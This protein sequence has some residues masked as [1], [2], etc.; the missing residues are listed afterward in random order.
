MD[1]KRALVTGGASGMGQAI[2]RILAAEGARVA[3]ADRDRDGAEAT[4]S[5]VNGLALDVDVGDAA[6]LEE[7]MQTAARELGGLSTLVNNAGIS[8]LGP[9][10]DYRSEDWE[11]TLEVN[12]TGVWNCMRAALPILREEGSGAAIVNNASLGAIRPPRG[13]V[14]YSAAKAGVVA[15]SCGAAQEFAPDIRVN[16][17]SPGLIRTPMSEP[18]FENPGLLDPIVAA[19]PLQRAG[20]SE[21]VA[22]AVLFLASDLSSYVT[23][24]NLVV[25]G[26]L[27]LPLA[28][29]DQTL[30]RIVKR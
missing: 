11:R 19:T 2:C 6:S 13:E 28:G 15:L 1:G 26:G 18:L 30:Q 22:R 7:A 12:L 3:V 20:T 10:D 14:A 9:V 17:V 8:I 24:Q 25:D 23:G 21:E 4:A 27:S 16:C 29:I 5:E